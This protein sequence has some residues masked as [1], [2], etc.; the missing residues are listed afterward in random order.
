M[1]S[2]FLIAI[3]ATSVY[4]WS[5]HTYDEGAV[6]NSAHGLTQPA[7]LNGSVVGVYALVVLAA[8]GFLAL[9]LGL[10]LRS[11]RR[12]ALPSSHTGDA[13]V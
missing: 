10:F 4:L 3:A 7:S 13:T 12:Q 1:I 5:Q 11:R 6:F 8:V 2:L 9:Q